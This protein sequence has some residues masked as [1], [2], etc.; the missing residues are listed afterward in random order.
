MPFN[1]SA[2]PQNTNVGEQPNLDTLWMHFASEVEAIY[3][4]ASEDSSLSVQQALRHITHETYNQLVYD[5]DF[6][7][8]FTEG[9]DPDLCELPV[10]IVPLFENER[11]KVGLMSVYRNCGTVPL[12][13]HPGAYGV[14]L[15]LSGIAKVS[16][17]SV[18]E[19]DPDNTMVRLKVERV[20]ERLPGQVCWFFDSENDL[21]S[22][23]AATSS[24]QLLVT[25]IASE[26]AGSQAFYYPSNQQS[27]AQGGTS[28]AK[29]VPIAQ[30]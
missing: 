10:N 24:A 23:E 17:A 28:I 15:V 6:L 8:A 12:H 20:R 29:R 22:I 16:H 25:Q 26:D 9:T 27:V 13:D 11:I 5:E 2:N 1:T 7:A 18:I 30:A 14:T 3:Q 21:H 4:R 19:R